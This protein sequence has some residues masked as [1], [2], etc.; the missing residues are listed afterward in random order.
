MV[1]TYHGVSGFDRKSFDWS[2]CDFGGLDD[3]LPTVSSWKAI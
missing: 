2:L 1:G 3:G